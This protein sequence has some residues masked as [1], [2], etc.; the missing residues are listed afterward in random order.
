MIVLI[1][2]HRFRGAGTI[3]TPVF[4]R[5]A[6][7]SEADDCFVG[8]FLLCPLPP[9]GRAA[10]IFRWRGGTLRVEVARMSRLRSISAAILLQ[11]SARTQAE[12]S[13]IPS[14][15]PSTNWQMRAT[16]V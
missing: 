12:A 1:V 10:R 2:P 8:Y 11:E 7:V 9:T 4:S 5:V 15:I 6:A 3:K 16:S 14:G 13:S